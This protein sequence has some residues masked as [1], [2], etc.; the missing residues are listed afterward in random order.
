MIQCGLATFQSRSS[1]YLMY[2]GFVQIHT[3]I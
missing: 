1:E 3:E 2:N